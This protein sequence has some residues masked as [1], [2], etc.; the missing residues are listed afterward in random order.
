MAMFLQGER[1]LLGCFLTWRLDQTV[2]F[3]PVFRGG[4]SPSFFLLPF[5]PFSAQFLVLALLHFS[6]TPG[7]PRLRFFA[8]RARVRFFAQY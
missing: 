4:F 8:V 2:L 1:S 6:F 5:T 3:A 7:L